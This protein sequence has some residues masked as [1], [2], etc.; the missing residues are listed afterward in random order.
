MSLHDI[1]GLFERIREVAYID[2]ETMCDPDNFKSTMSGKIS[3]LENLV[4]NLKSTT[5]DVSK[6]MKEN[7]DY[8]Y[9]S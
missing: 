4:R 5:K 8:D 7:P 2:E 6:T 9:L 3:E 1:E